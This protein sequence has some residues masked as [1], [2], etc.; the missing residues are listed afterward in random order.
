MINYNLLSD[1]KLRH[2]KGF[3]DLDNLI[4]E[5]DR[6]AKYDEYLPSQL[7]ENYLIEQIH[8]FLSWSILLLGLSLI[9]SLIPIIFGFVTVM[10]KI[11]SI[12]LL[13]SSV[14]VFLKFNYSV[15]KL[16]F[17]KSTLLSMVNLYIKT[18]E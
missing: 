16:P 14:L 2:S 4:D 7:I 5:I 10:M 15:K 8:I 1:F 12:T 13:I 17:N 6:K 3:R 11:S 18:E 9:N